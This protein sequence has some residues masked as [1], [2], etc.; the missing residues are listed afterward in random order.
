MI[1]ELAD[2]KNNTIG[3]DDTILNAMKKLDE[4]AIKVLFIVSGH[5]RL[6]STL[7]DGDIRRAILKGISLE[8][9]VYIISNNSPITA[10]E[11]TSYSEID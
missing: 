1:K 7:T 10:D 9:P 6:I 5:N 11:L 8:S 2:F 3:P 4:Q